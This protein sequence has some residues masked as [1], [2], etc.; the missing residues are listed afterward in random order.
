MW[1]PFFK[2]KIKYEELPERRKDMFNFQLQL[3]QINSTIKEGMQKVE[4]KHQVVIEKVNSVNE[5]LKH[6]DKEH[7]T[8]NKKE[9]EQNE[10]LRNLESEVKVCRTKWNVMVSIIMSTGVFFGV[11][12]Y[13]Y[14]K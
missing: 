2:N 12:K 1:I 8:L 13:F 10:R 5:K 14:G 4:G 6:F 3:E 9:S 11:F 7:V